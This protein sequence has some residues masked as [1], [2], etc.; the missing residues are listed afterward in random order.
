M[1]KKR[2]NS[3]NVDS[4]EGSTG[5]VVRRSPSGMSDNCDGTGIG[6]RLSKMVLQRKNLKAMNS[7]D[8]LTTTDYKT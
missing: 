2:E 3:E 5:R 7:F 6:G 4:E 1:D 8:G